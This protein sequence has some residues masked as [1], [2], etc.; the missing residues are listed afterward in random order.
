MPSKGITKKS[1]KPPKKQKSTKKQK[2]FRNCVSA[3]ESF[4]SIT[5]VESVKLL[6]KVHSDDNMPIVLKKITGISDVS[7][8]IY[9]H[10]ELTNAVNSFTYL[11]KNMKKNVYEV[12]FLTIDGSQYDRPGGRNTT[13]HSIGFINY[14]DEDNVKNCLFID[15]LIS[16]DRLYTNY[17]YSDLMTK[18]KE[19][20][21]NLEITAF[22]TLGNLEGGN[23]DLGCPEK[24]EGI[25]NALTILLMSIFIINPLFSQVNLIKMVMAQIQ[26]PFPTRVDSLCKIFS[27]Y[28]LIKISG[29]SFGKHMN[30]MNLYDLNLN[31][32]KN[33]CRK[34]SIK[35]YSN[36]R[37]NQIIKLIENSKS[38]SNS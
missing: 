5:P 16:G 14:I 15:C 17:W 21:P 1:K 19:K 9:R 8:S 38:Y 18:I 23:F 30:S 11:V 12:I 36:L 28:G 32:L 27:D 13:Q 37:K 20:N 4:T 2:V 6:Q 33:I 34:H 22:N 29:F 35:G 7:R 31:Q 25:C 24:S 3:L 10:S 26:I